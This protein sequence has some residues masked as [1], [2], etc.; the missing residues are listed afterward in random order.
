MGITVVVAEAG[1]ESDMIWL[2]EAEATAE[3][4]PLAESGGGDAKS[5]N[6]RARDSAVDKSEEFVH[7]S[8]PV[9]QATISFV[10]YTHFWS[11]YVS[12]LNT[13]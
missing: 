13:S 1:N 8:S 5:Q 12:C 6:L 3:P 11:V 4:E 9:T 10:E 7:V 2:A